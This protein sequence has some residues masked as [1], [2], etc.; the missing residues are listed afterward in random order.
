M[1]PTTPQQAEMN[2]ITGMSRSVNRRT[3]FVSTASTALSWQFCSNNNNNNAAFARTPGSKDISEA[4]RQIQGALDDLKKL[5]DNWSN[6]ATIDAEGRAGS[7][8]AARRILGGI[9]PQS[10]KAAIEVAKATPLYR[11]D[12][13]FAAIRQAAI[14]DD[15]LSEEEAWVASLDLIRFEELVEHVLFAIQKAD[16][17]FY[18]VLFASKGTKQTSGIFG[19]AKGQVNQGISDFEEI[20]QLLKDAGSPL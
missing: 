9:A 12:G 8:D 13:A 3:F 5:R 15:N 11:I 1:L 17:D 19:E 2:P 14:D 18:S 7:T 6:Y 4:A 20:L 16:G 10:G